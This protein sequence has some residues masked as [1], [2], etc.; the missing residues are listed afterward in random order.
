MATP[1][2]P[3]NKLSPTDEGSELNYITELN[4]LRHSLTVFMVCSTTRRG[5]SAYMIV[6]SKEDH[7][8][9]IPKS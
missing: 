9:Y 7:C 6:H 3:P 2:L 4:F 8:H 5:N 1:Y